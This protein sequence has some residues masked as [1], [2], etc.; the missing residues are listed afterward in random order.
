MPE[1]FSDIAA[2]VI[3]LKGE[4]QEFYFNGAKVNKSSLFEI[5]SVSKPLFA[6]LTSQLVNEEVWS[7]NMPVANLLDKQYAHHSY[8]LKQ[9]LT[10]RSGLPRLPSNLK[11]ISI[12]DPYANFDSSSLLHALVA[13]NNSPGQYEYSNYGYGLLGWLMSQELNMTQAN[14]VQDYLFKTLNMTDAKLALSGTQ[15]TKLKGRDYYGDEVP[16]WHFNSLVGA[17]GVL[18]S[19]QDMASWVSF[20]WLKSEQ[21]IKLTEAIALSLSPLNNDMAYA[22]SLGQ[23][24]S[25]FHGG[26]TAGFNTMVVFDPK[27]QIAVITMVAGERDAGSIAMTLFEQLQE[28]DN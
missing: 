13:P 25:Y 18:A 3:V 8:S 2:A 19:P 7:I 27:K 6:L 26:K 9:L 5:G 23:N 1:L 21:N 14:M 22:W 12:D 10:H 4:K 16:N 24:G 15:H 28:K 17:G 20:Y 11:P